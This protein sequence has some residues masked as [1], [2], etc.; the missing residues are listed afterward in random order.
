MPLRTFTQTRSVLGAGRAANCGS[1]TGADC[2]LSGTRAATANGKAA[3]RHKLNRKMVS[4][5]FMQ[6][7]P[8]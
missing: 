6:R 3:G 5:G 1:S 8:S 4:Q 7:F 2:C